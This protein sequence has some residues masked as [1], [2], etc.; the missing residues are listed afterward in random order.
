MVFSTK[1][2]QK[3]HMYHITWNIKYRHLYARK[4]FSSLKINDTY[5]KYLQFQSGIIIE[6]SIY[7]I[8]REERTIELCDYTK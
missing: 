5:L 4:D 1:T 8:L 3:Y 2:S 6:G 7:G